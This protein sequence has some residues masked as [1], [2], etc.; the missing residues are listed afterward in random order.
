MVFSIFSTNLF[1]SKVSFTLY[2]IQS[3]CITSPTAQAV[4]DLVLTVEGPAGYPA[5][6]SDFSVVTIAYL[7]KVTHPLGNGTVLYNCRL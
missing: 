5:V 2:C 6:N 3:M 7:L 1:I 4:F